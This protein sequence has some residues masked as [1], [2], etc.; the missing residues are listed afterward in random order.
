MPDTQ[1]IPT[2]FPKCFPGVL[3]LVVVLSTSRYKHPWRKLVKVTAA[4]LLNLTVKN[5]ELLTRI[6]DK[7]KEENPELDVFF[8]C[9]N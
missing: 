1:D 9:T 7:V 5:I 3:L 4:V 6:Q 8:L 2:R